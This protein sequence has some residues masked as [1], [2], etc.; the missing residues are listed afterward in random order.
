MSG[1]G[2]LRLYGL[3]QYFPMFAIP[4]ILFLFPRYKYTPPVPIFW[5]LALYV[6]AKLFEYFDLDILNLLSNS[7]SGHTLKHLTA[8]LA[9]ICILRMLI[10][11]K[12]FQK[13]K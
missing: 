5:A 2:D 12:R 4:I 9:V 3:V 13:L 6:S 7:L 10:N 1:E 8:T 11:S